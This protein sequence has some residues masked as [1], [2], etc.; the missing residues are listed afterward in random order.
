MLLLLLLLA[1]VLSIPLGLDLYIPSPEQNPLT[2]E[3]D[4]VGETAVCR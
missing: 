3:K 1:S 2:A 4:R